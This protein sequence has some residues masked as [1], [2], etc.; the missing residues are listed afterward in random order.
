[1]SNISSIYNN[2]I[3]V[4]KKT[5]NK[6]LHVVLPEEISSLLPKRSVFFEYL[7]KMENVP[8]NAANNTH[9]QYGLVSIA[10]RK[11]NALSQNFT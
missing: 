7:V 10:L 6:T 9:L 3:H 8:V 1:M 11:P 2:C 5:Q 4:H